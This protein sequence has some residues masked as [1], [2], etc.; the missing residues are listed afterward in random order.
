MNPDRHILELLR[1]AVARQFCAVPKTP[2][3]FNLLAADIHARTGRTIGVST[4]K[5]LWGYVASTHGV[6]FTTL[7]LLCRYIGVA[8]WDAFSANPHAPGA[9]SG[10]LPDMLVDT[11]NL[12]IGTEVS[13]TWLPDKSCVIGKIAHPNV[14]IVTESRN[15]K[16]LEAD[17]LEIDT[18]CVGQPLVV[19]NCRRGSQNLG[20]YIGARPSGI[21]TL[22]IRQKK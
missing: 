14:F 8:D 12:H 21:L 5:R 15:V 19:K 22:R 18:L 9:D 17:R 20:T 1:E 3:D 11:A 7:S 2:S 4:L 13:L 6:T 10:F 16:L